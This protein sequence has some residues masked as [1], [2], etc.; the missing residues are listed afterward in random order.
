MKSKLY[1]FGV[2]GL[3]LVISGMAR[4]ADSSVIVETATG[5]VNYSGRLDDKERRLAYRKAQI[6]ALERYI[7]RD[8]NKIR[9]YES[10][11]KPD[12]AE[13]IDD[14]LNDTVP[15][16]EGRRDKALKTF[17]H[18]VR[19][20]FSA[21]RLQNALN[22]CRYDKA[23]RDPLIAPGEP[24]KI[25]FVFVA[26]ER[27]D[28]GR[29]RS[30]VAN[31]DIERSLQE[32]FFNNGYEVTNGANLERQSEGVYRRARLEQRCGRIQEADFLDAEAA[33]A[34]THRDYFAYG[35]FVIQPATLDERTGKYR[36][37]VNGNGGLKHVESPAG[38]FSSIVGDV[39]SAQ[40]G[41]T[42]QEALYAAYKHAVRSVADK[43]IAQLNLGGVR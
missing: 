26:C 13:Q 4:A 38:R 35:T 31:A 14:I 39:Q 1:L 11:L 9:L 17:K 23:P 8:Q 10:C 15:L 16:G 12:I 29:M 5:T 36:V 25:A 37:V 27:L 28:D 6:N 42:A 18:K 20:E 32:L 22:R 7:E 2:L 43:M 40:L 21:Y 41:T 33:A 30:V 19:I 24:G 3:L 34:H